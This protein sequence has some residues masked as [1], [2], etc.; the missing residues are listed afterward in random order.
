MIC[1]WVSSSWRV[2]WIRGFITGIGPL[3][4]LRWW[5]SDVGVAWRGVAF[6]QEY[7]DMTEGSKDRGIVLMGQWEV[8]TS[9]PTQVNH[10]L[11]IGSGL[12]LRGWRGGNL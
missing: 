9:Q 4:C 12:W 7:T 11:C 5:A 8:S 6:V 1:F 3:E 2:Q 10:V